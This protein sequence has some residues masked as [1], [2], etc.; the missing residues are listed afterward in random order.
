MTD[1]FSNILNT[2]FLVNLNCAFSNKIYDIIWQLKF[3]IK[4]FQVILSN[5]NVVYITLALQMKF[6][7]N[8]CIKPHILIW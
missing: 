7:K 4:N 3:R 1:N 2:K 8:V 5:M 6:Q